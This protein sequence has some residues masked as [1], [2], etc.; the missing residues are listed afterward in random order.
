MAEITSYDVEYSG[1]S[2]DYGVIYKT[3]CP[4]CGETIECID[5]TISSN[6]TSC[7]CGFKWYIRTIAIGWKN[8]FVESQ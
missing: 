4:D 8:D 5:E 6:A 2:S 1:K 7:M 3:K